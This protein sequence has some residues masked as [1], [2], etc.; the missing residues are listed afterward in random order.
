MSWL[1]CKKSPSSPPRFFVFLAPYFTS[2][3]IVSREARE[4]ALKDI[5]RGLFPICVADAIAVLHYDNAMATEGTFGKTLDMFGPKSTTV[6]TASKD[7]V[8]FRI[9]S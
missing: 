6:L 7:L 4:K 9:Y 3:E 2:S 1:V 8:S 5:A